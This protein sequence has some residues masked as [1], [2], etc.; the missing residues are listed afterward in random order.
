MA[1]NI[2]HILHELSEMFDEE[3]NLVGDPLN[4]HSNLIQAVSSSSGRKFSVRISH[5]DFAARL[6]QQGYKTL[7]QLKQERPE[8]KAPRVI[9][10]NQSYGVLDFLEGEP[11]GLW[12]HKSLSDNVRKGYLDGLSCFYLTIWTTDLPD[13]SAAISYED[14][15]RKEVDYAF[16]RALR[17]TDGS[18]GDPMSFL[19]RRSIIQSLTCS[20]ED[21]FMVV[22]HGDM[23]AWNVIV[24]GL[25]LTG[26]IDWDYARIVPAGS[27]VQHPL[28]IADIPGWANDG[29][30]D[31]ETFHDD[32]AYLEN[33]IAAL[34]AIL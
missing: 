6:A 18:W 33:A 29:V 9:A 11:I 2:D 21:S 12:N 32:R 26:V 16:L 30:D 25:H 22:R 34:E 23:N 5:D 27:A 31:G 13:S 4:G 1:P 10:A 14:W 8:L 3:F 7:R 17:S 24:N 20:P 28:F 19:F 15:L